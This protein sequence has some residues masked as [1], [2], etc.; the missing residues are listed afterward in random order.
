MSEIEFDCPGFERW[1]DDGGA[2]RPASGPAEARA[3]AAHAAACAPCAERWTLEREVMRV[4]APS[5]P[6]AADR[7]PAGFA[8]RVLARVAT[9][10]QV[11]AGAAVAPGLA[12][13]PAP[14]PWWIRAA[15]QPACVLALVLAGVAVAVTPQLRLAGRVLPGWSADAVAALAGLLAHGTGPAAAIPGHG[16]WVGAAVTLALLPLIAVISVA[17]YRLGVALAT[18]RPRPVVASAVR[19]RRS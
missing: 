12:S 15:A 16:P 13:F 4:L 1:L 19:P 6:A 2:A 7:A 11:A 18:V 10:S 17:L 5:A 8:D 3:A 14:V 9:T